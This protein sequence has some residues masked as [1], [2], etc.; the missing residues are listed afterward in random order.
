MTREERLKKI[1]R[2]LFD[3]SEV[4]KHNKKEREELKQE[5]LRLLEHDFKGRDHVLPVKTIEVPQG[6]WT[7]T[8]M[9]KEEF[10]QSRFPGWNVEHVEKNVST[11]ITVFVLKQNPHYIA[12]VVE[13]QTDNGLVKVSKEV[14]EYTPEIDWDTLRNERYDLFERLAKPVISLELDEDELGLIAVEQP[15]ELATLQR[16]MKVK[17][18]SLKVQP[19]K[20][21]NDSSK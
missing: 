5:F 9:T 18:P 19:R 15:E 4:D 13:I 21:K 11:G 10:V 6:F 8:S 17:E 1:A 14:A 16:H 3:I 2:D 7:A 12:G 20:V